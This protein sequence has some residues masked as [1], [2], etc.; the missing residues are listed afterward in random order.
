[1]ITNSKKS[2]TPKQPHIHRWQ[3][4]GSDSRFQFCAGCGT[5]RR[6][7]RASANPCV[8][9]YGHYKGSIGG[10]N[11]EHCATC[12]YAICLYAIEQRKHYA[13]WFECAKR[14]GHGMRKPVQLQWEAC[15]RWTLKINLKRGAKESEAAE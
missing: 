4:F 2:D 5:Q 14:P 12:L 9:L 3:A 7:D 11:E 13:T 1:M 10:G 8:M 15:A 6:V